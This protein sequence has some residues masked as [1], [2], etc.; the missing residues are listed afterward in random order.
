MIVCIGCSRNTSHIYLPEIHP[1]YTAQKYIPHIPPRNT[2]QI[3]LDEVTIGTNML[4]L[5]GVYFWAVYVACISGR[6]MWAVFLG[7][8]CGLYFW[9]IY[10]DCI[11]L[12]PSKTV[13]DIFSF[14]SK[15]FKVIHIYEMV[16][17]FS[18]LCKSV[19]SV[20]YCCFLKTLPWRHNNGKSFTEK[21]TFLT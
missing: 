6:Y 19:F 14:L 20:H 17:H 13:C 5:Y 9:A 8:I 7:G 2:F 18:W 15:M 11:S 16:D 1:T 21:K 10:V 12:A 4:I 3:I